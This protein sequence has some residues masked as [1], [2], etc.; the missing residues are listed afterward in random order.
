MKALIQIYLILIYKPMSETLVF[1]ITS[2][3]IGHELPISG[4][5]YIL[6]A[7]KKSRSE[8]QVLAGEKNV[9]IE[10]ILEYREENCPG[11]DLVII[12]S[13][14]AISYKYVQVTISNRRQMLQALP[15]M[16]EENIITPIDD[17]NISIFEKW[18]EGIIRVAITNK[19]I[20]EKINQSLVSKKINFSIYGFS[21]IIKNENDELV[22]FIFDRFSI[23]KSKNTCIQIENENIFDVINSLEFNGI[24]RISTYKKINI[25]S[26]SNKISDSINALKMNPDITID[27]KY[28]EGDPF[29][30]LLSKHFNDSEKINICSGSTRGGP[31]YSLIYENIKPV[32]ITLYVLALIQIAFNFSSGFYFNAR[33]EGV[34][35]VAGEHYLKKFPNESRVID[36][37]SQIDGKLKN[38]Q[39]NLDPG[40]FSKIFGVSSESI[41][42]VGEKKNITMKSV[43]YDDLKMELK[44][45]I[46]ANNLALLDRLKDEIASRGLTAEILSANQANQFI[47]ATLVVRPI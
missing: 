23:I 38:L 30:F 15:Y 24:N 21:D 43:R 8:F 10:N 29:I 27:E 20:I 19:N 36:V 41:I 4:D 16:I 45:E 11:S 26:S 2:E 17:V 14:D 7:D 12:L 5:T 37:K 31:I 39:I 44:I 3:K 1:R 6:S 9:P 25:D 47:K 32:L 28:I 35:D 22:I 18:N 33:A 46:E 42:K 40:G 13:A 34:M